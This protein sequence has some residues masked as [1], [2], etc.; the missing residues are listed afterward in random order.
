MSWSACY[1][2][3]LWTSKK[4]TTYHLIY[5]IFVLKFLSLNNI[6]LFRENVSYLVKLKQVV[7]TNYWM[8]LFLTISV[9]PFKKEIKCSPFW[10]I[11]L[12]SVMMHGCL[13][14]VLTNGYLGT[15]C[16][17]W[18]VWFGVGTLRDSRIFFS[19]SSSL[20]AVLQMFNVCSFLYSFSGILDQKASITFYGLNNITFICP[21]LNLHSLICPSL[22][23]HSHMH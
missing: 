14:M 15:S 12:P 21:S 6:A 1:C 3:G 18:Q 10:I 19:V 2:Y 9:N 13:V 11:N 16:P 22:N 8:S 4:V 23:L 5:L 7:V 20:D 17:P